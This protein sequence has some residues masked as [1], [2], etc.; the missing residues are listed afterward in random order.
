MGFLPDMIL[1]TGSPWVFKINAYYH[2][3]L[4]PRK[5]FWDI[6]ERYKLFF[7][8]KSKENTHQVHHCARFSATLFELWACSWLSRQRLQS[9]TSALVHAAFIW[10]DLRTLVNE[11]QWF[12]WGVFSLEKPHFLRKAI[13]TSNCVFTA[14][15]LIISY[16]ILNK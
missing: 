9:S 10:G 12:T 16:W 2:I 5:L 8:K 1:Q 7:W 15:I 11:A 4:L 13:L 3:C 14:S 6:Q